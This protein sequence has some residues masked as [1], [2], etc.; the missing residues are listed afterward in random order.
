MPGECTL[1]SFA[2]GRRRQVRLSHFPKIFRV[3]DMIKRRVKGIPPACLAF[4]GEQHGFRQAGNLKSALEAKLHF[5][6]DCSASSRP[7]RSSRWIWRRYS[8]AN[9][10]SQ[11]PPMIGRNHI[12]GHLQGWLENW[13]PQTWNWQSFQSGGQRL[14]SGYPWLKGTSSYQNLP[15]KSSPIGVP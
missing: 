10:Y 8:L 4:A 9:V 11:E 13:N 3:A 2:A 15:G 6:A 1:H 14:E 5:S 12:P 7:T